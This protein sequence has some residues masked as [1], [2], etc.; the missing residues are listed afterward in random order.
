[1]AIA[2]KYNKAKRFTFEAPKDF[3]YAK[4]EELY[5]EG[6]VNVRPLKAL[7]INTKGKFG[8]RPLAVTDKCFVNLPNHMLNI[9]KEML[10]DDELVKAINEDKVAFE[11]YSY[12]DKTYNKV[13]YSVN[14]IDAEEA[15]PELPF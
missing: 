5:K 15:I 3:S 6:E 8:D 4:L 10:N 11:I 7:Y 9:V 1:M 12:E 14:W 13:C 2:G